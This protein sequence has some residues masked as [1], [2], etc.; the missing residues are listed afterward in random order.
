MMDGI[1]IQ[2]DKQA[3]KIAQHPAPT[4]QVMLSPTA[5]PALNRYLL[6]KTL[7]KCDPTRLQA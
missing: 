2:L 6:L 5:I 1:S 3:R 4:P 7:C